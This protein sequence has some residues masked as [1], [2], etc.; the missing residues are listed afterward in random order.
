MS[1][2]SKP[3]DENERHGVS[4][5]LHHANQCILYIEP[6]MVDPPRKGQCMLGLPIKDIA[7]DPKKRGQP[8]YK[9]Q[10]S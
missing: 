7:E 1:R 8:L 9:G 2:R 4:H 5:L 6:L 10:N 3:R